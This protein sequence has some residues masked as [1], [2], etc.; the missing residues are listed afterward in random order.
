MRTLHTLTALLCT[1]VTLAFT[2]TLQA[3][4]SQ[5][6]F[7]SDAIVPDPAHTPTD[8]HVDAS[9]ATHALAQAARAKGAKIRR[10]CPVEGISR[11]GDGW[12]LETPHSA[13]VAEHIVLATSFWA[14]EMA[15]Q[16]G[17]SLPLYPLQ[18]HEVITETVPEL[19]ALGFKVPTGLGSGLR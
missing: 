11:Y 6:D 17:L 18:H 4:Q 12:R 9:G 10:H 14:R 19:E 7:L 13:V 2:P 16:I 3:A 8:G 1:V 5:T 15:E